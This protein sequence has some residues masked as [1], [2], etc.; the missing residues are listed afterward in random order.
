VRHNTRLIGNFWVDLTRGTLYILLPLSIILALVLVSQGVV[1]TFSPGITANLIQPEAGANHQTISTQILAVGPV[2]SQLAIKHLGTN[3]GGFFNANAAHPFENP[4]PL[5]D[6]LLVLSETVI[7]AALTYTFGVM[8]GDTRQG[9]AIL[10]A[11]LILL[12]LFSGL[13]YAAESAPNPNLTALGVDQT[14]NDLQPGGNLEGKELRFGIARSALFATLTTATSTGAVDSMHDSF[15]PLGGLSLM[16]MMMVGEVALGGV[17]SGLYGM[18]VFVILA[19][20]V[21]GL[22]VG[23]TPEYLGKK[24]EAYEMKMASLLILIMPLTVLVLTAVAVSIDA[25]QSAVLNPGPH[26]FSEILYAFTSQGNNNGSAFAGLSGN[27]LFYNLTGAL[28]MLIG[29]FGLAAPTLALAGALAAKKKVPS[30]AGTLSTTS[31]LFIGWL[32]GVIILV[33]ALN[34]VPALALGPVIEHLLMMGR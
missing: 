3:G 28:A 7:A 13:T 19:V 23:R 27:T 6:F 30:G 34:F 29:R 18:L 33:G 14:T 11:M 22:M 24:I 15:M 26:G 17:G 21:A 9:W 16:V 2:A 32:I 31:G 1:Q 12:V 25:A 20:F 4:N 10:T 8:V 5:T